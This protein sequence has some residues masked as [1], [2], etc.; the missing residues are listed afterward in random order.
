MF[1]EL[2]L[3]VSELEAP[4]PYTEVVNLLDKLE[5]HTYIKMLHRQEP[6]PL[7]DVLNTKKLGYFVTEVADKLGFANFMILIFNESDSETASYCQQL[8]HNLLPK[9]H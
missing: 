9:S 8:S 7:Y 4:E 6:F 1:T 3:D 5:L 2:L